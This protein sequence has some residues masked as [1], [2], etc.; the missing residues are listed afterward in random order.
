MSRASAADLSQ[1]PLCATSQR[2]AAQRVPKASAHR[3]GRSA[4]H[5]AGV[6]ATGSAA[7]KIAGRFRPTRKTSMIV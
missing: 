1:P 6:A 7:D 4:S 2:L 5:S 3:C